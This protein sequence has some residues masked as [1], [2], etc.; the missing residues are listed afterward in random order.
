MSIN[1]PITSAITTY[2]IEKII[3]KAYAEAI[4]YG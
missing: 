3:V 2:G 1:T 4:N